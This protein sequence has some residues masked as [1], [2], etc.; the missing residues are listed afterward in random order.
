MLIVVFFFGVVLGI[1]I[2]MGT[3]IKE[4]FS[5]VKYAKILF[6]EKLRGIRLLNLYLPSKRLIETM[7]VWKKYTYISSA[8][9]V[10]QTVAKRPIRS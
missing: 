10:T 5:D 3:S 6:Q 1:F 7:K 9:V 4:E 2:F 8:G